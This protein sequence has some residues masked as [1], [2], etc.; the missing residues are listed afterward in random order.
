MNYN[1]HISTDK[2]STNEQDWAEEC[3][4]MFGRTGPHTL[5]APHVCQTKFWGQSCL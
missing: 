2:L 1:T 3:S 4:N 5:G